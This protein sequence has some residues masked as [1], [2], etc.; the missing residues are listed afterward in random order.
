MRFPISLR[1]RAY[2]HGIEAIEFGLLF[3][4]LL[5]PFVWM[6]QN[7]MNFHVDGFN[8]SNGNLRIP[9]FAHSARQQAA[10][11]AA[12]T[13]PLDDDHPLR[14]SARVPAKTDPFYFK[15]M[16]VADTR[17]RFASSEM[18]RRL[19][20]DGLRERTLA[21]FGVQGLINRGD[22][23]GYGAPSVSLP[24]IEAILTG[25]SLRLPVLVALLIGGV[26]A[27]GLLGDQ[28]ALTGSSDY[29]IA[30]FRVD[31]PALTDPDFPAS[32]MV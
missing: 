4:F 14:V 22:I 31:R 13:S 3:V 32:F 24:E 7:G 23:G 16:N 20:P 12:G 11:I 2:Q 30:P 6:F 29:P 17:E 1:R 8:R 19:W 9:G 21:S 28:L 26:E 27:L 10:D 15:L 25:I 18:I 5:P